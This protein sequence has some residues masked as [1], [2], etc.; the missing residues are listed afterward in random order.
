M[1]FMLVAV[2]ARQDVRKIYVAVEK[3]MFVAHL[4]VMLE[5]LVIISKQMM[6]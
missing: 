6:T 2:T 1:I 5:I 3:E 4:N